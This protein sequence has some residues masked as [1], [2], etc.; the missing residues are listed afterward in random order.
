MKN[1][2]EKGFPLIEMVLVTLAIGIIGSMA[3]SMLFQGASIY[4]EET[5]RQS[6][7]SEARSSF[8]RLHRDAQNQSRPIDFSLS[9]GN[10]LYLTNSNGDQKQYVINSNGSF[11]LRKNNID[12]VLSSNA[13]YNNSEF[14]FYNSSFN[15]ISPSSGSI[16]ENEAENIRLSKMKIRFVSDEDSINFSAWVFPE[17]FRYGKKMSYHP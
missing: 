3:A 6:F 14:E 11:I 10:N 17:N 5:K 8:W 2:T 16:S 12:Y 15:I 1:Y 7:I 4:I 13:N 9:D